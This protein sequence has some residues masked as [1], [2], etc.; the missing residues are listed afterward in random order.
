[1]NE[2]ARDFLVRA[3]KQ[4]GRIV[5]SGDLIQIQIIEAQRNGDFWVDEETGLGFAILPWKL[6]TMNDNDRYAK[7]GGGPTQ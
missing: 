6:T 7:T 2:S 1:M 3:A 5:S 4:G